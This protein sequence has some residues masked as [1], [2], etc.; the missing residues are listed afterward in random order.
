MSEPLSLVP[1]PQWRSGGVL[2]LMELTAS[3]DTESTTEM[4]RM[5]LCSQLLPLATLVGLNVDENYVGRSVSIRSEAD[6]LHSELINVPV[7]I[8]KCCRMI[9]DLFVLL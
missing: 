8:G 2:H 6:Q 5:Y 7:T 1:L 4:G 3:L 9:Q